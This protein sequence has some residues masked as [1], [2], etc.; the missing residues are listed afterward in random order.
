MFIPPMFI[1]LAVGGF[2][3]AGWL[4][5]AWRE[6]QSKRGVN[7][8]TDAVGV[9]ALRESLNHVTELYVR[10]GGDPLL[11]RAGSKTENPVLSTYKGK[12]LA[13]YQS[14]AQLFV[15]AS[16]GHCAVSEAVT[17]GERKLSHGLLGTAV[18]LPSLTEIANHPVT[19]RTV[20]PSVFTTYGG[21]R[22]ADAPRPP[23]FLPEYLFN[24]CEKML[25]A[26]QTGL[27]ELRRAPD[28]VTTRLAAAAESLNRSE[29]Q[30]KSLANVGADYKPF[31][32]K[33]AVVEL[34]MRRIESERD[35]DPIGALE[36]CNALDAELKTLAAE[37]S[38]ATQL[39][40]GLA[41]TRTKLQEQRDW[42]AKI[43]TTAVICPWHTSADEPSCWQLKNA[44]TNPDIGFAQCET[45]IGKAQTALEAGDFDAAAAA[46]KEADGVWNHASN[47][48][49]AIFAAKNSIDEQVPR[50]QMQL[51]A[52][53][54]ELTT[55]GSTPQ[56]QEMSQLV[57]TTCDAIDQRLKE[58]H[59]FYACE[60]FHESLAMI[61]GAQGAE[62][63]LPISKLIDQAKNLLVLLKEA[64]KAASDA[65][66]R[67]Q[68]VLERAQEVA[69]QAKSQ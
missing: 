54:G 5:F 41:D 64:Q 46:K 19:V 45:F 43:R 38:K 30:V 32:D 55:M 44:D 13:Q 56:S 67:A 15:A 63:G 68:Q 4:F 69:R 23:Q 9:N 37:I 27:A 59:K 66:A 29:L 11:A 18:N 2:A 34:K 53:R 17:Q 61:T 6:Q 60:K 26:V 14:I 65:A 1:W 16:Y 50:L 39:V 58:V 20:N 12:T 52:V 33:K 42:V 40:N 3:F 47:Q 28:T 25:N 8:V 51:S 35:A 22:A 48:V 49:K 62:Q 24:A 31:P 10:T 7:T 57:S 36:L 21:R